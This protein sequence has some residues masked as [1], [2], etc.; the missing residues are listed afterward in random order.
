MKSVK[1]KNIEIRWAAQLI[2]EHRDISWRYRINLSTPIINISSGK[3]TVGLWSD[4]NKTLS[5]S[6]HLIKNEIWDV[7]LEVL[8]HEMAHQY[9]S[10]FYNNADRHGKYFKKACKILGVHPVFV[11][12]S[13]DYNKNLQAF[14]GELS[15]EAQKMLKKVEK[16]MALGKSNS[17]AEAK[18]A[19]RKANYLLNKY[20]LQQINSKNDNPDIKYLTICH[21]KKRIESIQRAILS[22]LKNYYCVNCLTSHI[23]HVE[24]DTVYKSIVLV[25]RKEALKVAEYIYHF[26]FNTGQTLWQNFKKKNRV[27][28]G[29]KISFDM[30]FI[31]GIEDNH[32]TVFKDSAM[33]INKNSFLPV[34]TIKALMEKNQKENQTE[35]SRLFPKL[36]TIRYGRHQASSGA[37]KEGFK[38]G[39]K[40][41]INKSM[42]HHGREAIGLLVK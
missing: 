6:S 10:E 35:I 32:K 20:N 27:Q 22:I 13:N 26:L 1:T 11:A 23:Y 30:G 40:T 19:S 8:K 7:V 29:E 15:A 3:K 17:E 5:I 4:K 41:H 38:N 12:G 21:K 31:A 24:D 37:F 28:R 16:L 18:S 34:K 39:K 36:K 42:T 9:V 25:G 33:Q 2:K 14:K